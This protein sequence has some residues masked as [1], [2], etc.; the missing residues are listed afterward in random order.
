MPTANDNAF[1]D[2]AYFCQ[3]CGSALVDASSFAGG[4]ASCNV[5]GWAGKVE[6]LATVP[7]SQEVGSP[8]E[9]LRQLFIDIRG[10]FAKNISPDLIRLLLKW[11]FLGNPINKQHVARYFGGIAR[12]IAQGIIETRAQLEKEKGQ[13]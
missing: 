7:F 11:G 13:G 2:K 4:E 12:S 3:C 9:V 5:C 8:D 10:L 6:E 1:T